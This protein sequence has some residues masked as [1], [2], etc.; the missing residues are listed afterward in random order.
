MAGNEVIRCPVCGRT[1]DTEEQAA[2]VSYWG[3]SGEQ[4]GECIG[5][6]AELS[7]EE[8]VERS[9]TVSIVREG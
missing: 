4:E 3:E 2:Y 6:D 1:F 7:I 8:H 5:C 9:Y